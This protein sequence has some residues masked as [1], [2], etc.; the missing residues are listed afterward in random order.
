MLCVVCIVLSLPVQFAFDPARYASNTRALIRSSSQYQEPASHIEVLHEHDLLCLS[1][2]T[3]PG[4]MEH[5]CCQQA[6]STADH[7]NF[8]ETKAENH[9]CARTQL[10]GCSWVE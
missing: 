7:A 9:H 4:P 10:E 6:P 5:I 2:I 1:I 3:L 8:H